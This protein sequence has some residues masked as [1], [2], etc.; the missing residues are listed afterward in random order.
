MSLKIVKNY[1]PNYEQIRKVLEPADG[2]LFTYGDT[3]YCPTN[4]ELIDGPLMAHEE[5]HSR[6]QEAMG[7]DEWWKEYLENVGFR[8]E[9]ELEAYKVQ[10]KEAKK[11]IKDR[12]VLFD[13][14]RNLANGLASEM[15]GGVVGTN[16][17][18]SLIKTA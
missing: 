17:A 3:L 6:Q 1:P 2:A 16:E 14:L 15:Y 18:M 9:Q 4:P 7:K 8:R 10:Y 5:V 12:N 13:F 11:I